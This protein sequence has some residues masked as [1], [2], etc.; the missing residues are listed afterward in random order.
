M[1]TDDNLRI[2]IGGWICGVGKN[3]RRELE[4]RIDVGL[5]LRYRV[6]QIDYE[7][8]ALINSQELLLNRQ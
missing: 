8:A 6:V 4:G 1:G 2:I 7:P 3:A 5:V